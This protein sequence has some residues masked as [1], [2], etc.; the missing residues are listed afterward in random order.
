MGQSTYDKN[1]HLIMSTTFTSA[2]LVE[3][4]TY[5]FD[6][7]FCE[8]DP[9]GSDMMIQTSMNLRTNSGFQV[10][11]T[12]RSAGN[13]SFDIWVSLSQGQGCKAITSVSRSTG[14]VLLWGTTLTRR[15]LSTG[16]WFG[17]ITVDS[18]HGTAG[19]D[20]NAI[21]GLPPGKYTLRIA[22]TYDSTSHY[23]FVFT[24]PFSAGPRFVAPQPQRLLP[25]DVFVVN[26]AS[27]NKTGIDS[28]ALAFHIHAPSGIALYADSLLTRLANPADTFL[29]GIDGNPRRFWAVAKAAGNWSLTVGLGTIDTLDR[30]DSILV[31]SR[32]IV[33][34]DSTGAVLPSLG[35]IFLDPN[36]SVIVRMAVHAGD[37]LCTLCSGMIAL[38]SS[39]PSLVLSSTKDGA[40]TDSVVSTGGLASVW[41]RGIAAPD[42]GWFFATLA[43]D[44]SVRSAHAPVRI[45][46]WRLRFLA[47][48]SAS[49]TMVPVDRLIGD[50]A[51]VTVQVWGRNGLCSSC[52]GSIH[53]SSSQAGIGFQNATTGVA[54]D[55]VALASGTAGFSL[56]G[57]SP[58]SRDSFH[59]SY[60]S[61][62]SRTGKPVTFRAAPPDSSRMFDRNGDGRADS[63]VVYLHRPWVAGNVLRA[64]W[65]DS[66][67]PRSPSR[68]VVLDSI[69]VAAVYDTPFAADSTQSSHAQ[70]SFSWDGT[71]WSS[72]PAADGVPP[73]PVA[74]H[75]S[76]GNGT[77]V[78][79]TLR[80]TLSEPVSTL[81][82]QALVRL[83]TGAGTADQAD[84]RNLSTDSR[85]LVLLWNPASIA[86]C[87]R[88]CDSVGLLSSVSDPAGNRPG[89]QGKKVV[90][91]GSVRPPRLATY[92]DSNGDGRI[93]AV[94]ITLVTPQPGDLPSFDVSLPGP[95]TT[96]T[97]TNLP[98]VR[99]SGDSLSLLVP[100]ASPFPF[101][102]TSVPPGN[103][104]KVSG[105][106]TIPVVDGA[107]PA[108]D[109]AFVR[110][111]ESYDGDDTL[112]VLPSET[113]AGTPITSW[114][115]VLQS[116]GESSLPAG[117][118]GH[119]GDTL[120][121]VLP[122]TAAQGVRAGDSL[123][124]TTTVLDTSG[125]P[126]STHWRP[127]GGSPRP[128]FLRITPPTSLFRPDP[129][130][131]SAS[132]ALEIQVRSGSGWAGTGGSGTTICDTIVCSGP[133]M[134]LN[135]PM[136]MRIHVYD[137]LGVHVAATSADFDPANLPSDRLGRVR[138]RI[139]WNGRDERG[140]K[141][142]S[143]VYLLRGIL[144]STKT[145]GSARID[146]IV[147]K[148]GL[149]PGP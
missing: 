14:E 110:H 26:V 75:I 142:A 28:A 79:D 78:P 39:D 44:T 92:L 63:L 9:P 36:E 4:Q 56:L 67:S 47:G 15:Q 51:Q 48:G 98:A 113:L 130:Q 95:T 109:T 73:V 16:T 102:W 50:T 128:T 132:P 57:K 69:T 81:A 52:T 122:S 38:A 55:S 105:G 34:L 89:P 12:L 21:T 25:G 112:L 46:P 141:V 2:H 91:Q 22:A 43:S 123:R 8:C 24:V 146:N 13:H 11:D 100:L 137:L 65:P 40:K 82:N 93:D 126:A 145:N 106:A 61:A 121:V 53:L 116:T 103:W 5:P 143:G 124:W 10:R 60:P 90:I 19:L 37:T 70:G 88:P 97:R 77:S 147:W 66:L 136:S 49:D 129:S 35:T 87:P 6:F 99:V 104:A 85:T 7:F 54:L 68:V 83:G 76:W 72:V 27:Y 32:A 118:V 96:Q 107:G 120:V 119:L 58:V 23:D 17:G 33:F 62:T 114:W 86:T 149:L 101:G 1:G 125:N 18:A 42:S 138:V 64:S 30:W 127:V 45:L 84:V 20:S 71:L 131:G 31:L 115:S 140:R 80:V 134:E 29:T 111:T 108:I 135:Q 139:L 3:G 144:R 74:A 133:A 59:I 117:T 41:I 94:R 148:I